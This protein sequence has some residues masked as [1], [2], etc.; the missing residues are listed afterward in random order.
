MNLHKREYTREQVLKHRPAPGIII[1]VQ[2]ILKSDWPVP[3]EPRLEGV[4]R[5]MDTF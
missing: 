2:L 5:T 4:A 3:G 1:W